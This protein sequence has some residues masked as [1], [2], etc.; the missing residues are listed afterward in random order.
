MIAEFLSWF[1]VYVW[2]RPFKWAETWYPRNGTGLYVM[3][4]L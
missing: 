1:L 2:W 4:L 3:E